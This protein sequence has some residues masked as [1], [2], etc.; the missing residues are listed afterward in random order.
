MKVKKMDDVKKSK[1]TIEEISE[2]WEALEQKANK[3]A[4]N[5]KKAFK[6]VLDLIH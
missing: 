1:K 5:S 3:L 4:K 2:E 6:K